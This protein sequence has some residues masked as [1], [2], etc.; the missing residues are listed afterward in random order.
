[1]EEKKKRK[2]EGKKKRKKWEKGKGRRKTEVDARFSHRLVLRD[3]KSQSSRGDLLGTY[4]ERGFH[5]YTYSMEK[6]KGKG[7]GEKKRG[8]GGSSPTSFA[9]FVSAAENTSDSP[10]A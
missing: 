10:A 3:H 9:D 1:V 8:E 6:I 5:L 7:E 2:G 4:I